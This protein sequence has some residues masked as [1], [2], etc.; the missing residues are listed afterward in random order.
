MPS[1]MRPRRP[2]SFIAAISV[3][4]VALLGTPNATVVALAKA[5][6]DTCDTQVND[7]PSKLVACVKTKDLWGHMQALEDIA[8]ANPSPAD[9]H[10]SR[11]SG[12]PGYLAS[13]Q[14]VSNKMKA[15]GY[16]VTMQTYTFTYYAYRSI[17]QLTEISPTAQSFVAGQ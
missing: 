2:Y 14:Y 3:A 13:A 1:G 4:A 10:P 9:G 17:P 5:P 15:A 11:N 16:N 6:Q 12:E 7:T 8:I